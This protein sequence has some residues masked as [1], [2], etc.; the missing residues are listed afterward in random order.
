MAGQHGSEPGRFPGTSKEGAVKQRITELKNCNGFSLIEG[1]IAI[2]IFGGG[3]L[4]VIAMID[5]GF[6][7]GRM[8]KN[9]TTC[10]ELAASMMDRIRFET[11][12]QNNPFIANF[13]KLMSYNNMDTSLVA[14]ASLPAQAS[15]NEWKSLIQQNLSNGQGFVVITPFDAANFP[16]KYTVAVRVQWVSLFTHGVTLTTVIAVQ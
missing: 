3:L 1:L 9:M 6:N 5:V 7:S 10:N 12:E 15:Y 8:S 16:N 2:A 11:M 14:P 4:A 13:S